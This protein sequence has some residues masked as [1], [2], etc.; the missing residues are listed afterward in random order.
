MSGN[1]CIFSAS[2]TEALVALATRGRDDGV[3]FPIAAS[4]TR[5]WAFD[6]G[7]PAIRQRRSF[8]PARTFDSPLI[9]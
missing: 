2:P 6:P 5:T 4:P 8:Y 3:A 7:V 1:V 9:G